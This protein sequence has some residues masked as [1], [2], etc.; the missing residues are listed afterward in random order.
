MRAVAKTFHVSLSTVQYWVSLAQG[1][2]LDRFNWNDRSTAPQTTRRTP[3]T[4][5]KAVIAARRRLKDSPLGEWGA[6]AILRDLEDRVDRLPALRTVGRILE[7]QG[8]LDGRKRIRRPPP[9]S[10]WYLPQVAARTCELDCFD[11]IEGLAIQGGPHLTILTGI[12]LHGGLST[13]WPERN[14]SAVSVVTRLVEHWRTQGRPGYAQ[15]DN[16]N[17]FTGPRQY[18]DAIGRVIRLCLSLGIIPV[19]SV[20]NETGFQASI[21]SFNGRWQAKVWNRYHHSRLQDLQQR[22]KRYIEA[23]RER[24]AR[25]IDSAPER[26]PIPQNWSLNLQHKPHGKIIFIRRTSGNGTVEILGHTQHVDRNWIHR[27]V[28]TEIDLDEQNISF[29]ALRR[30]APDDQP[31]LNTVHYEFP[32]KRFKE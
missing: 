3:R 18:P 28:R 2:R 7:R 5:E 8:L 32:N 16:D 12:S 25:R 30:R 1:K 6:A 29:Y 20:P 31:L 11:T 24:H 14:V 4:T 27:L 9:P 19:F 23:A 22:S 15:F 26:S 21:E 10:G 13:A 17:R